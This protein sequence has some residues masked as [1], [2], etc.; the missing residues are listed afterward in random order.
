MWI[1]RLGALSGSRRHYQVNDGIGG[2]GGCDRRARPGGNVAEW[3]DGQK[4]TRYRAIIAREEARLAGRLGGTVSHGG[5]SPGK[6][7]KLVSGEFPQR[8]FG[9]DTTK[10]KS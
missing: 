4:M 10:P 1:G 8:T 2:R 6:I 7:G 9:L 5:A 3:R